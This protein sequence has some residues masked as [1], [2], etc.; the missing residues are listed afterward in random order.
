MSDLRSTRRGGA[1]P[2][3]EAADDPRMTT[4]LEWFVRMQD[5]DASAEERR[6]FALWLAADPAN[7]AAL[8]RAKALWDRFD[9]VAEQTEGRRG[10]RL[11]R[12]KLLLSGVAAGLAA[13]GGAGLASR[14]DLFA[15]HRT[16]I[17]ER[18]TVPLPNGVWAELG[19]DS[20][21]SL[22]GP[23]EGGRV[24]LFRGEGVFDVPPGQPF[25]V[26][27]GPVSARALGTRF[28]VKR[29]DDGVTVTAE[30]QAVSV[31]LR[32]FAPLIVAQGWQAQCEPALPPVLAPADLATVAAWR[33]DRIVF[34]DTPLPRAVAE[35][36][37]Y[38]SGRI[39]LLGSG[40][41]RHS[42]TAAFDARRADRALDILSETLPIRVTRL[43][44]LLTLV[45]A[46]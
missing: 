24:V 43:T 35:L 26:S 23:P 42:V 31:E 18:R 4:A 46:A 25:T 45:R 41:Q 44:P 40:L 11:D 38:R 37:R 28:D 33:Q 8:T 20:A 29:L 10:V 21:L 36:E 7:A 34:R 17:G 39:L 30:A 3:S 5:D 19:T 2:P 22:H 27:A 16:G 9:V 15:D 14:P 13:G 32:G 12:R 1:L 6:R